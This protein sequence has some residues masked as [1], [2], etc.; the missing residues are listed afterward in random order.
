MKKSILIIDRDPFI[1]LAFKRILV[2]EKINVL[3]ASNFEEVK[4]KYK[5]SKPVIVIFDFDYKS[6]N[7]DSI[8]QLKLI[9]PKTPIMVF[10]AFSNTITYSM[11]LQMGADLYMTKPFNIPD[12]LQKIKKFIYPEQL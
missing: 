4:Q 7:T 10:T 11:A 1:L 6:L 5:D 2:K 9:F 12:M 3:L 8:A